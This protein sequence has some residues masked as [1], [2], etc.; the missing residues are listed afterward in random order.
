MLHGTIYIKSK[1][2]NAELYF[3]EVRLAKVSLSRVQE[4]MTGSVWGSSWV[5]GMSSWWQLQCV[6][7]LKIHQ[8]VHLRY[9]LIL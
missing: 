5:L 6:E 3:L 7:M 4:G 9:I 2:G 8:V 1:I